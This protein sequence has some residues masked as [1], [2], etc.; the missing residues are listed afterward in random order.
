MRLRGVFEVYPPL[1]DLSSIEDSS[2]AV[3]TIDGLLECPDMP[4]TETEMS[5]EVNSRVGFWLIGRFLTRFG[6]KEGTNTFR[7]W[8]RSNRSL[9]DVSRECMATLMYKT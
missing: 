3:L 4:H 9:N 6:N 1:S 2:D 7:G 5:M 8:K